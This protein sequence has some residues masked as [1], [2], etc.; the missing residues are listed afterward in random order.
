[1]I[2]HINITFLFNQTNQ[3][4]KT[5]RLSSKVQTTTLRKFDLFASLGNLESSEEKPWDTW[6]AGQWNLSQTCWDRRKRLGR[7]CRR[8][9]LN[10]WKDLKTWADLALD[11]YCWSCVRKPKIRSPKP[12]HHNTDSEW[13][14]A[15]AIRPRKIQSKKKTIP[16]SKIINRNYKSNKRKNKE[17]TKVEINPEFSKPI[18]GV[19]G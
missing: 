10:R 7:R 2:L 9:D 14:R 4:R 19:K 16:C 11:P 3:D 8:C 5:N 12:K 1:M 15:I 6:V 13:H 18:D 17:E